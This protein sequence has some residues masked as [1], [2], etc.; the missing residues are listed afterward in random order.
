MN[1]PASKPHFEF[2]DNVQARHRSGQAWKATFMFSTF[3]GIL[4][5]ATLLFNIINQSSGYVVYEAKVDPAS[6][7]MDGVPLEKQTKEQ[8]LGVLQANISSGAYNK[9]DRDNPFADQSREDVYTLV[10]ERIVKYK[11]IDSWLLWDSLTKGDEITQIVKTEYPNDLLRFNFWFNLDFLQRKQSS[12][13]VIAGV[14]TAILGS[15]WTIS[16]TIL[17]AFP[18]GVMAAIY[19][20]EYAS[21]NW[22][23]R[24]IRDQHQ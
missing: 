20:E 1:Q 13:P 2:S 15:L 11:V 9:L 10:V 5:L 19:L 14:R 7:A 21:D 3:I 24:I 18:L 6:L 4:A 23:T 8:L 22:L 12:D 17:F 16:I